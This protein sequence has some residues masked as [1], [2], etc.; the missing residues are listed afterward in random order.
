MK[1]KLRISLKIPILMHSKL[2]NFNETDRVLQL[3]QYF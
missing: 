1:V 2:T 3:S